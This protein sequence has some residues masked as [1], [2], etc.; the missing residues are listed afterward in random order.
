[1]VWQGLGHVVTNSGRGTWKTGN[2]WSV[3]NKIIKEKLKINIENNDLKDEM[4]T[5][6]SIKKIL[7]RAIQYTYLFFEYVY[8]V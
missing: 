5:L 4:L 2:M 7:K 1:M 8:S 6:I 3:I